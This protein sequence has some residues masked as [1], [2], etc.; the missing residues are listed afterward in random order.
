MRT[1]TPGAALMRTAHEWSRLLH[2]RREGPGTTK[3]PDRTVRAS[4]WSG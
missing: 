3:G 2:A 1:K 4:R